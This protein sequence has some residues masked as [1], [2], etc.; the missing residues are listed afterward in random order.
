ME[1]SA[2]R[3]SYDARILSEIPVEV[4]VVDAGSFVGAG[5]AL[6]LSQSGAS[7]AIKRL[8]KR[9]G[10]RLFERNPKVIRLTE[11]G[12]KFCAYSLRDEL[13]S[14]WAARPLALIH[15]EGRPMLVFE[16]VGGE[17]LDLLLSQPMEIGQF[18]RLAIAMAREREL[19]AQQRAAELAKANEALRGCLDALASV[20]ELAENTRNHRGYSARVRVFLAYARARDP[21]VFARTASSHQFV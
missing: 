17:P 11:T 18:L 1:K 4:A 5:K 10:P 13:D 14:D 3:I 21:H 16:D 2:H 9:L 19:F 20:P 12:R 8:E 6:G 15:R 7:R